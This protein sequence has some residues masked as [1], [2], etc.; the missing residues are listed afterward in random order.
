MF[1][2]QCMF[3]D[4]F[5]EGILLP[6]YLYNFNMDNYEFSHVLKIVTP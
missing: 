1:F 4:N 6:H 3:N 5:Y 2:Y